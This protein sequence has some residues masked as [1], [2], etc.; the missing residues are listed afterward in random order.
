MLNTN[1]IIV[2]QKGNRLLEVS[3]WYIIKIIWKKFIQKSST[4]I[5]IITRLDNLTKG[6][7][8][9]TIFIDNRNFKSN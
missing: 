4:M 8:S 1:S 7:Y 5:L 2:Y 6:F 3:Y 9:Y